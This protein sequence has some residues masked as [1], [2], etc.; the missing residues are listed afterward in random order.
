[1]G[2]L[3]GESTMTLAVYHIN[4]DGVQ[5]IKRPTTSPEATNGASSRLHANTRPAPARSASLNR[6]R[7]SATPVN[8]T[9]L[10]PFPHGMDCPGRVAPVR[11]AHWVGACAPRGASARST[12]GHGW[13]K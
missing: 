8:R 12:G 4:A 6:P 7:S 3:H 11:T 10:R 5:V 9:P 1:M 13:R 2:I